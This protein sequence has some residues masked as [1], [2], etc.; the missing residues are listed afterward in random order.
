MATSWEVLALIGGSILAGTVVPG[1][2]FLMVTRAALTSRV[3]G[4]CLAAGVVTMSVLFASFALLGLLAVLEKIPTL[5]VSLK[6]GG[7]LYLCYIGWKLWHAPTLENDASN[8]AAKPTRFRAFRLGLITQASNPKAALVYASTFAAFMPKDPA[9]TLPAMI[10]IVVLIVS[11]GWYCG[12]AYAASA[13][14]LR[15]GYT[16]INKTVDRLSATII[17]SLGIG[18]IVNSAVQLFRSRDLSS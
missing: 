8:A 17:T 6:V 5:Y 12:V 18:I 2:S 15:R 10:I 4:F 11:A 1:P 9:G 16:S 14:K 7:G 13:P 3:D